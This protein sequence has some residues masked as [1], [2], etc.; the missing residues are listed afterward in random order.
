MK[1]MDEVKR[2]SSTKRQTNEH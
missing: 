2:S 1:L